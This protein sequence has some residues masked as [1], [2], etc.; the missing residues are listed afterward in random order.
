[1]SSECVLEG[2]DKGGVGLGEPLKDAEF[3]SRGTE[4]SINK[5][6]DTVKVRGYSEEV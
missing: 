1:M 5:H 2:T 4:R 3:D 6:H